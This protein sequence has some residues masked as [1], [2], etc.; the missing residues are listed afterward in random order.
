MYDVV[1]PVREG[2]QHEEL[3]YSLRSLANLPHRD[4]W[5]VG[6]RPAWVAE[7]VRYMAR[8]QLLSK[9]VNTMLNL[10]T[11]LENDTLTE[12]IIWCNDDFFVMQQMDELPVLH[13]GPITE[14]LADYERRHP[15]SSY[16]LGMRNTLAL[17]RAWGH[18]D[19]LAYSIHYPIA[20]HRPTMRRVLARI[21]ADTRSW[22]KAQV[23]RLL[24]RNLYG[25]EAGLGGQRV[26]DCKIYEPEAPVPD[27]AHTAPF[28]STMDATFL[29]GL[30]GLFIRSSFPHPGPYETTGVP[31]SL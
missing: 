10:R 12:T 16:T 9:S 5:L 14:R 6:A 15:T 13:G 8:P 19:P 22:P 27:W 7:G 2:R 25:N 21:T 1:Y 29:R 24:L 28:L 17:L 30:I 18:A 26:D 4:V 31:L 11:A 3:R 20:I 23:N